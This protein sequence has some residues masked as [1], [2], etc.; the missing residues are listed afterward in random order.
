M[1]GPAEVV[2]G[3]AIEAGGIDG[4]GVSRVAGVGRGGSMAVFA[5]DSGFGG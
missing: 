5:A 3:G 2:Q 1:A 4:A